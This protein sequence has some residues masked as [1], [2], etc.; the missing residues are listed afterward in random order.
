VQPSSVGGAS[1]ISRWK[2]TGVFLNAGDTFSEFHREGNGVD[3]SWGKVD[4]LEEDSMAPEA[5][6][7]TDVGMSK[8]R[9]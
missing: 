5:K 7:M 3:V 4:G 1:P 8:S 9:C 2:K 6:T